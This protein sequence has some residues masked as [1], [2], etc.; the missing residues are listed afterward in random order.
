[1]IKPSWTLGNIT[2]CGNPIFSITV[3]RFGIMRFGRSGHCYFSI[4]PYWCKCRPRGFGSKTMFITYPAHIGS[5]IRENHRI[6]L[7][8]TYN[9]PCFLMPFI[10]SCSVND[11]FPLMSTVVTIT[12]IGTI[13][14]R[15]KQGAI[16]AHQFGQLLSVG[17]GISWCT[18]MFIVTVPCR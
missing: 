10:I 6:R 15:G 4:E 18:I 7:K 11:P 17:I 14:P 12:S 13:V 5:N 9:R 2:F 16:I 1:M 3:T 8:F